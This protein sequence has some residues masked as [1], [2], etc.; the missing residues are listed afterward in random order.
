MKR[1]RSILG[2]VLA[3]LMAFVCVPAVH[4]GE[5]RDASLDAAMNAGTSTYTY[6]ASIC[7]GGSAEAVTEGGFTY[8]VL[9]AA[10]EEQGDNTTYVQT[11]IIAEAGDELSFRHASNIDYMNEGGEV[12]FGIFN[13]S[14]TYTELYCNEEEAGDGSY[15]GEHV[16]SWETFRYT[17]TAAGAYTARWSIEAYGPSSRFAIQYVLLTPDMTLERAVNEPGYSIGWNNDIQHPWEPA[18]YGGSVCIR[19]GAISHN[20]TTSLST[21]A[22]VLFEGDMFSTIVSSSCE[23]N[24]DM[25]H[26]YVTEIS[27]SNPTEQHQGSFSGISSPVWSNSFGWSAPHDGVYTFRFEYTKDSSVSSGDD[28]V[29]IKYARFDRPDPIH[30]LAPGYESYF[31]LGT[32]TADYTFVPAYYS[33]EF[34]LESNNKGVPVNAEITI[35]SY[36][37]TGDGVA[38]WYYVSCENVYDYFE[39]KVDGSTMIEETGSTGWKDFTYTADTTGLHEFKFIYHKDE[40][41]NGGEDCVRLM[42]M[43]FVQDQLDIALRE[44]GSQLRFTR[45]S[46]AEL[47]E[48][49]EGMDRY[50]ARLTEPNSTARVSHSTYINGFE[51]I[52]FDYMVTGDAK[53]TFI[54]WDG[55]ENEFTDD[56]SDAWHTYYYRIPSSDEGYFAWEFE[57]GASGTICLDNIH[58]GA[59]SI[60]IEEAVNDPETEAYPTSYSYVNFGGR[61][62]PKEPRGVTKYAYTC[63]EDGNSEEFSW[64]VS[65]HQGDTYQFA[66]KYFDEDGQ[67]NG[68]T[69][70]LYQ[71]GNDIG[72]LPDTW[73]GEENLHKWAIYKF[74]FYADEDVTFRAVYHSHAQAGGDGFGIALLKHT[75]IGVTLDEALN[76]EG[77]TLH[78]ISSG[79]G[80]YYP[81]YE[82]DSG[83]YYGRPDM[84]NSD[85]TLD[86]YYSFELDEDISGWSFVDGDGD[87]W[88][89]KADAIPANTGLDHSYGDRALLSGAGFSSSGFNAMST[90]NWA[91]SPMFTV[92]YGS[93]SASLGFMYAAA[94]GTWHPE[95]FGVYVLPDGDIE[96]AVLLDEMT[97]DRDG[98]DSVS[99]SL[100]NYNG[101]DIRIAFRHYTPTGANGLIIDGL[102]LHASRPEYSEFTFDA[103]INEGDHIEFDVKVDTYGNTELTNPILL[104]VFEDGAAIYHHDSAS[105]YNEFGD[106]WGRLYIYNLTPGEH[107]YRFLFSVFNTEETFDSLILVDEF[108][109]VRE[110]QYEYIYDV[111]VLGYAAPAA[112]SCANDLDLSVPGGSGYKVSFWYYRDIETEEIIDS[113]EPLTAGRSYI[114][115]VAL[116]PLDGF[117]FSDEVDVSVANCSDFTVV[118]INSYLI[119]INI[120]VTVGGMLGDTNCDGQVTMADVTALIAKV[121]NAGDLSALGLL[122]ADANRDGSVN[123]LDAAA[124]YAIA[125]NN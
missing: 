67:P 96:R 37:T 25:L 14:G 93:G 89:F 70:D 8:A 33:D 15:D 27:A 10:D 115:R 59:I 46:G 22:I 81:A 49:V 102:Y 35:N 61:Y 5:T 79:E 17:F 100:S 111:E 110:P 76:V 121:M 125:F 80:S 120:P 124:I 71:N 26:V 122:N 92:P 31:A 60:P 103:Q 19:S 43:R 44:E 58:F 97:T 98:W 123:I 119:K 94:G 108:E 64:T 101:M 86:Q 32:S 74:T 42:Q 68:S 73:F 13:S 114:L 40:S 9:S 82:E 104:T 62:D 12:S 11:T 91:V 30:A 53:L 48:L 55:I 112:G 105:M 106:D 52:T 69:L 47:L 16:S 39:I 36:L 28:C 51:Y 116:E 83:R 3:L 117:I 57:T 78:F 50:Y 99:Y 34:I 66:F 88:T 107:T 38:L 65:G 45:G 85:E 77:G 4:A 29:Y 72:G 56:N 113:S 20:Q 109:I 6:T 23:K 18:F 118:D 2:T 54:A 63:P 87:G 7:R 1:A 21:N 90:D 24:Y 84:L 95:T 41:V 75:L